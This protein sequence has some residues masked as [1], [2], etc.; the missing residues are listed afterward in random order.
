MAAISYPDNLTVSPLTVPPDTTITVPGSKSITNRSLILAALAEGRS[1]VRDALFSDDTAVMLDSLRRLGFEVTA[2]ETRDEIV[3]DGRGGA[4]PAAEAE[5]FLGNSGTSIRFLT[6][7]AALGAGNYRLDGVERMRKRPQAD[8]IDALAGL[9]VEVT[10]EGAPGYPPL[11]VHGTGGIDGGRVKVR[12]D[13][14]SQFLSALLMIGP[15]ARRGLE[16]EV[17][18]ALRPHH[19]AITWRMMEMWGA[20][21]GRPS[22]DLFVIEPGRRY[23][24]QP[25]WHVEPD[26][27]NASYMFAAAAV[28]G[29]RVTVPGLD[30]SSL[31][32][33]VR[34]A[35]EILPLTGC[36]VTVA[37]TSGRRAIVVSGPAA[38]RLRGIDV[39]MSAISDTS[40][41]LA[42]IAPFADSP[43]TI[44][45]IAHTRL[46]E[47][48]RIAAACTELRRLGVTVDEFDDG[49]RIFPEQHISPATVQTYRDHRVAMGFALIGLRAPGVVIADPGCVAK[50]FPDYW[51]R[52]MLLRERG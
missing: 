1:T 37:E 29:G 24:A 18:G 47:C 30:E 3:I 22:P 36:S 48:D 19:V 42:A 46:Q 9:G 35:T 23:R 14:S 38:G 27:S 34:F 12:A 50:T 16:L 45:G 5:L 28:T 20:N 2:D 25:D 21:V 33:D 40:L 6:A 49:L 8:L 17:V 10:C 31:Q 39:D 51:E 4:I 32:G 52:L 41:T 11:R 43:T 26:A 15:F 13:A 44:R 7:L